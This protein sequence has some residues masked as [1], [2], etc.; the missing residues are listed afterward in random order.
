MSR[1]S[2]GNFGNPYKQSGG[3]ASGFKYWLQP[4]TPDMATAL[5]S[6]SFAFS[7]PLQYT[8]GNERRN[9]LVGPSYKNVD[10]SLQKNFPIWESVNFQFGSDFFNIFNHT[11]YG[12][13][14]TNL[15]S[16]STFG[17]ITGVQGNARII[18]LHG[19]IDF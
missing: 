9:D 10:F 5:P 16:P 7:E 18:Q 14:G 13:F 2:E 12:G 8:L 6:S 19:K 17:Q 11:N 1:G 15:Q 3:G 4:P